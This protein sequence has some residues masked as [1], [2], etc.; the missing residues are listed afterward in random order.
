MQLCATKVMLNRNL[1]DVER[2]S[3]THAIVK[4]DPKERCDWTS[5]KLNI[6]RHLSSDMVTLV[7]DKA[8]VRG[9]DESANLLLQRWE[10]VLT[11][12]TAAGT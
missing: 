6:S 8:T 12:V 2:T 10:R 5:R 1:G 3:L 11:E 9:E 7:T 4:T